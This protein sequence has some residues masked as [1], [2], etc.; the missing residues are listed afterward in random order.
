MGPWELFRLRA[1]YDPSSR[2]GLMLT[3]AT[4]LLMWVLAV[5][6]DSMHREIEAELDRPH[7]KSSQVQRGPE[8][9]PPSHLHV[10]VHTHTLTITVLR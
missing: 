5:T 8:L 4:N 7:G 3:L 9:L 6:N 10:C 1:D 2:C